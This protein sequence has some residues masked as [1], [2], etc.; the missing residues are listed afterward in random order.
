MNQFERHKDP[1]E[2]LG[3]GVFEA[4]REFETCREAAHWLFKNYQSLFPDKGFQIYAEKLSLP[5]DV[6]HKIHAYLKDHVIVRHISINPFGEDDLSR[7][8]PDLLEDIATETYNHYK[9]TQD[10]EFLFSIPINNL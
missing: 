4:D 8:I 2:A 6:Y 3:I 10:R 1:K 5:L 9:K 7:L